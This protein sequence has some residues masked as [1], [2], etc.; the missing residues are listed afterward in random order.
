MTIIALLRTTK[1]ALWQKANGI[2]DAHTMRREIER[3]TV[4]HEEGVS[5]MELQLTQKEP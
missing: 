4:E 2:I 5:Q 3:V 1:E